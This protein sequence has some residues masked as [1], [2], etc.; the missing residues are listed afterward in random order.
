[1]LCY[2][3][4]LGWIASVIFLAS[5]SYRHDRYVRF[6]AFQGLFLQAAN[7]VLRFIFPVPIPFFPFHRVGLRGILHLLV[8]IAQVVGII[9]TVQRQDYRVPIASDL[10]E[11]S[12]A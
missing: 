6:H 8:V 7:L 9:K 4:E 12:M 11:K 5:D 2:I 3:P 10:A 1:M